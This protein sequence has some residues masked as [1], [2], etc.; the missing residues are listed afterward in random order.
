MTGPDGHPT[1]PWDR[2]PPE[3]DR[4]CARLGSRRRLLRDLPRSVRGQRTGPEARPA[5][6]MGRSAD[7]PR[8]QGR[9]PARDRRASRRPR[10]P[11]RD[12]A[13]SHPDLPVRVQPS[14]SRLRLPGGRPAAGRRR[15]APRSSSTPPMP[16]ACGSSSTASSITAGAGSGRSTTSWRTAPRRRI[17]TGSTSTA[18]PSTRADSWRRTRRP[19]RRP[20]VLGYQAWWGL[21]ALPKLNTDEPE[22]REYLLRVAEHWLRFGIDGWRL[23]VPEEIEDPPFWQ[24]FRR[25]CRAIRPDAYLVGEVWHV[26]P[27][28][29]QGDRFDALMDYP[30]A[31]AILGFAGGSRLD[32]ARRPE[33]PG[34][35]DEH[36]AARRTGIR[37]AARR[38]AGGV[39]TGG[40]SRP[41]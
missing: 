36:L 35:R 33:P 8:V 7:V 41:S 11:R 23:D 28:W 13:L 19:G 27:E 22:V 5:R 16:A 30:L 17:G 15:G 18:P 34:V 32:M 40:R 26:A 31:E 9:R 10:G 37:P 14:I 39:R 1:Q 29:L 2:R 20:S 3:R 6:A 24:E 21:A 12:R 4:R 38:S 25:R